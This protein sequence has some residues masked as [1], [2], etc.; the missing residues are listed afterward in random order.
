[1]LN[2]ANLVDRRHKALFLCP[3]CS[4][5]LS[6]S[7]NIK[8]QSFRVTFEEMICYVSLEDICTYT[9]VIKNYSDKIAQYTC[10]G[11]NLNYTFFVKF[12]IEKNNIFRYLLNHNTLFQNDFKKKKNHYNSFWNET[13]FKVCH[14]VIFH[15]H[16]NFIFVYKS[17][18]LRTI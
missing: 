9:Y 3:I 16:I 11:S 10:F 13:Y 15:L 8:I 18:S 17:I 4:V 5:C 1:M 14:L 6:T 12:Q 7:A 2:T